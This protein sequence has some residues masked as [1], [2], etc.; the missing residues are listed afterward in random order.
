[1]SLQNLW[2]SYNELASLPKDFE[3]LTNLEYLYLIETPLADS[4][5]NREEIEQLL[6]KCTIQWTW[7]G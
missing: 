4:K 7:W 5:K 2:L 1:M 6:P 3:K